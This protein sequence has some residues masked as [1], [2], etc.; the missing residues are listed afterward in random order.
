MPERLSQGVS[1]RAWPEDMLGMVTLRPGA[2]KEETRG[3]PS[4]QQHGE[5]D[6]VDVHPIPSLKGGF[7]DPDNLV[8]RSY[9]P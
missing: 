5:V 6:V 2:D 9:D 3:V 1:P 8:D 4:Y 7:T